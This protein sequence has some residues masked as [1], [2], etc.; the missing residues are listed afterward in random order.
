MEHM[1]IASEEAIAKGI[2]RIVALTGPEAAKALAKEKL[3]NSELEKLKQKV[4]NK[5]LSLKEKTKLI[6][7]LGYDIDAA[8]ISYFIKDSFRTKLKNI[9]KEIDDADRAKKNAVMGEVVESAKVLL[10]S[11]PN[12]PY[13]VHN[14]EAFANNKA[15]DGALKQVKALC[16]ETPTIFF[17]VDTDTSKILCMAQC[18]KTSVQ[19]GLKANEWCN[20]VKDLIGGK[21]GGKPESAQAS[22]TNVASLAEAMRV[23]EE[24]AM[25]KLKAEKVKLKV[26]GSGESESQSSTGGS[27]EGVVSVTGAP[28]S[29]G[30]RLVQVTAAL[31]GHK[32]K[33]VEGSKFLLET[34]D[35]TQLTEPV[36]ATV[37]LASS[38]VSPAKS[39]TVE[40]YKAQA[41]VLQWLL[42]SSGDL[43]HAVAGWVL[44]TSPDNTC[45]AA[46]PGTCAASKAS[47]LARLEALDQSLSTRTY[48]VGERISL[49][50]LSVALTLVPA[51]S[52]VLDTKT[53][54]KYRHVTRWFRTIVHQPEVAAVV[55][56]VKFCEKE[57]SFVA[58]AGAKKEKKEKPAAKKEKKKEEPK[59]KEVKKE[60]EPEPEL[61]AAPKKVDP[62]DGLPKGS[63]DLED[64]KRFYSNN[65]E[66]KSCEYFWSKFDPSCYSIWR[67]DYRYNSELTQIFMSCNLMGGM[68]QRL[69]K[70]NK[71]A[72]AS[73]CLF[74]ENNNSSISSIWVFKGD[75]LAFD[76]SEDWQVDYSSYEWKKL[77]PALP[78][79]KAVVNQYWKWEGEDSEGRKFNQGKIFK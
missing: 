19:K 73:A 76:L 65:D 2:R 44:P 33:V 18:S 52:Q 60:A 3:L 31:T 13:L 57:P 43:H 75:K 47:L 59:K 50:D 14:L 38:P 27:G 8:V 54:T 16:P 10:K 72:F 61:P 24:F 11:N 26:T 28:G 40:L 62:L 49:A 5:D 70:L 53:R 66:D 41:S 79:T 78:E 68:F 69:D 34:G 23:A 30:V 42:Y 51:F 9:K 15:V 77:D 55:G 1:V 32:V 63:F 36:S 67:G 12:L 74:G 22:G 71:N 37:Y 45:S 46:N 48:L 4:S 21:G 64:W 20:A 6:T 29:G 7:E 56:D 17:S 25:Q 35:G 39:P 58:P